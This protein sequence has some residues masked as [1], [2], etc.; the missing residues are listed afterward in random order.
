MNEE[1]LMTCIQTAAGHMTG[2]AVTAG[3]VL[4][5]R[6]GLYR[7]LAGHGPRSATAV[8]ADA[9]A[10]ERLVR[11]WLDGQAAAGVVTHDGQA[12]TYELS[13]EAA[14]VYA[15]ET[16][17]VFLA[18][19]LQ[20][21][22]SL[23]IDMDRI[24]AAY[25]GDGALAWDDH[26]HSMFHG[27]EWFFRTGYRAHLATEW[28]PA[29]DGVADALTAGASVLDVGCGHGASLAVLA[30]AFPAS[31]FVG[32]DAH[33]PS[34]E[35]A[36]ERIRSAGVGDRVRLEVA[37]AAGYDGSY[38]LIC[39]FDCLHDLGDPVGAAE[40][41]RTHLSADGSVLV[42]D[43]FALGDRSSNIATNPIAAM[44]YHAS[45]MICTPHSLSQGPGAALG[46]QAGPHQLADVFDKAGFST[47]DVRV[48][49][50]F[51]LIVQAAP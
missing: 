9:G 46:G 24:E 47:F 16:S 45:A 17:P 50:P 35:V 30:E 27:V 40:H 28:I 39:F 7:A 37:D 44:M 4:G 12:D 5:D 48:E 15:D 22:L 8:A 41:A 29:L 31:R 10:N 42:V 1:K 19:G 34:I 18:R 20:T 13:P 51:N 26:H 25:R 38:D 33:G 2:A 49:T 43:P 6:L 11:E 36:A 3:I 21:L 32:I 23:G 14:M